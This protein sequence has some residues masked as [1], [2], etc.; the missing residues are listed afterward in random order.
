[1]TMIRILSAAAIAAA[2][3][4]TPAMAQQSQPM[5]SHFAASPEA[6][7]TSPGVLH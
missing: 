5:P 1:M 4:A 6:R 7:T 3:L 2:A